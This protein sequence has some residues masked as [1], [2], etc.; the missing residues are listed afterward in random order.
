MAGFVCANVDRLPTPQ[1]RN[2]VAKKCANLSIVT[3]R[4]YA[5]CFLS[6]CAFG[7]GHL[8]AEGRMPEDAL[9]AV[10]DV[11]DAPA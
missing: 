1:K 3:N 6:V 4:L 11:T 9:D 10:V 2:N 5:E 7:R 8:L